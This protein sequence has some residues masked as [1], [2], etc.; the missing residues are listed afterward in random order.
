MIGITIGDP[1]GIG[2]E[3]V[4]KALA[5]LKTF[6]KLII[7]G[8][9]RLLYD[10]K[11]KFDMY[12]INFEK[13]KIIDAFNYFKYS[14]GKPQIK[15]GVA[16]AQQLHTASY[17][18]KI[19]KIKGIVTAPVSKTALTMAGFPFSGQ[20]EYFATEFGVK[21]FG[22]LVWSRYLKI[23]LVT[24]HQPLKDVARFITK[25]NVLE[26]IKLL[27]NYLMCYEK[28]PKPKIGVLGLNP[29]TFEFTCGAEYEILKAV[30]YARRLGMDAEGPIP[31]DSAFSYWHYN[32]LKTIHDGFVAMYHDQG[33]LP[34][35][36]L[37]NYSG[38]NM[39]L[40]LPF[41]RTSPLHGVAFDIAH[42]HIANA[43]GMY[44]AILLCKKLTRVKC[45]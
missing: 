25:Q 11:E 3:I 26:K 21:N 19:G 34:V 13:L 12:P 44:N 4:L 45:Y 20:T 8:N 35:K 43:E 7:I 32:T 38:V 5:K 36:L 22:M 16:V 41:I 23:V 9:K 2:P 39:T 17:L 33:I 30:K 6:S 14:Y 1:S 28:I 10:L 37:A 15:C 40:G 24:I 31:A 42:K 18:L 29:H 27:N